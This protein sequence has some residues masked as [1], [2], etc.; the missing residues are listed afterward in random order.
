MEISSHLSSKKTPRLAFPKPLAL[1]FH[2][3]EV[4][5]RYVCLVH[6]RV[7]QP[8]GL[9]DASIRTLRTDAT[10]RCWGVWEV[11][12][13]CK[14][15]RRLV[16]RYLHIFV[17]FSRK[18]ACTT[19]NTYR[20]YWIFNE[21]WSDHNFSWWISHSWTT[22]TR[23]TCTTFTKSLPGCGP[24]EITMRYCLLLVNGHLKMQPGSA[25]LSNM[26]LKV[27]L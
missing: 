5:K 17:L 11:K 9:V 10:T 8:S 25:N 20:K 19:L 12:G 2:K 1:R 16:F 3:T 24:P 14:G 27:G 26:L 7:T 13:G 22:K 15:G 4:S 21:S 6:G 23:M 18:R